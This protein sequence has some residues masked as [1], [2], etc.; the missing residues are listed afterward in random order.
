MVGGNGTILIPNTATDEDFSLSSGLKYGLTLGYTFKNNLGVEL[1]VDYFNRHKEFTIMKQSELTKDWSY[2]ATTF[3]P[4]VTFTVDNKKSSFTGK[5]GPICV[6]TDAEQ[7]HFRSEELLST[8]TFNKHLNWGYSAGIEYNYHF[9]PSFALSMELGLE[10][11]NFTPKKSKVQYE[12]VDDFHYDE[13][14]KLI[15]AKKVLEINYVNKVDQ[16]KV[17][18][19]FSDK[20][21]KESILFNSLYFGIGIK[22][23]IGGHK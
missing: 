19:V 15:I 7:S 23:T 8:C 1:G 14:G 22:Y 21:F 10:Q 6:L 2:Q 5:A 9:S 20:R 16:A 17:D 13:T 4:A 3:R 11:Y 12:A 18:G